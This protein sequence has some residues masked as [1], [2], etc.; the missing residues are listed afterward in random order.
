M[1]FFSFLLVQSFSNSASMEIVAVIA[2]AARIVGL[3]S[4]ILYSRPEIWDIRRAFTV[5][6]LQKL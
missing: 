3:M 1:S 4:A 2:I 6:V 5:L